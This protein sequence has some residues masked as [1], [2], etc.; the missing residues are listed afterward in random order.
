[1]PKNLS[2]PNQLPPSFV[3]KPV[4]LLLGNVGPQRTVVG[5]GIKWIASSSQG[6]T[7]NTGLV[8]GGGRRPLQGGPTPTDT[9]LFKTFHKRFLSRPAKICGIYFGNIF[10]NHHQKEKKRKEKSEK[11]STGGI[12]L[13]FIPSK[14]SPGAESW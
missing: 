10:R 12:L 11:V 8:V 14:S 5:G 13:L 9:G 7:L 4:G 3:S 6:C 1:M 2:P